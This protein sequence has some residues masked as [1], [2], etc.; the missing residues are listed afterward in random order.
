MEND[1]LYKALFG[2]RTVSEVIAQSNRNL[3]KNRTRRGWARQE[4]IPK[5][6]QDYEKL[7]ERK[8]S[9]LRSELLGAIYNFEDDTNTK[10]QLTFHVK[11]PDETRETYSFDIDKFNKI[12]D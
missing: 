3:I 2:D 6:P 12:D 9:L 10:V 5:D 11:R 1:A 4:P 7:Y 8:I